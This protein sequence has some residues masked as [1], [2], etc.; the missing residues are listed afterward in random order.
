[1]K[2][3]NFLSN[4]WSLLVGSQRN[5]VEF[6]RRLTVGSPSGF[7][8]N[9]T[10]K[11]VSV[12]VLVLT[13][14]IGNAWGADGDVAYTLQMSDYYSGTKPSS[15]AAT[16]DLVFG[17]ASN[18]KTWNVPGNV[19][20]GN[21]FAIG[22][23][24]L[25]NTDRVIT[26]KST[27]TNIIK[28][29]RVNYSG[30]TN[31]KSSSLT[32]NSAKLE[33]SSNSSFTQIV[34]TVNKTSL[35]ITS[36]SSSISFTPS[37]D[38]W[39]SGKYYRITFT[40]TT[41]G[42]KNSHF[43]VTSIVFIEGA[44]A[45]TQTLTVSK[46]SI[47]G[48]T[49]VQGSGPSSAQTFTVSGSNLTANVT[50]SA[51]TNFEVSKDGSS[52]A[53]SQTI[54]ASSTLSATTIYVRLKSGLAVNSYS[55][56]ITVASTGATSKTVSLS[57]SV[58]A[59][60]YTVQFSTG[61]GNPTVS[62]RTEASGGAGITLPSG[63]TPACSSDGWSFAGWGY[64]SCDDESTEPTLYIAGNKYYPS[65]NETLYAVYVKGK[66]ASTNY[67]L[68]SDAA[69]IVSG[70]NYVIAAYDNS[71]DYA[72]TA[73]IQSSY[74]IK[75]T[76]VTVTAEN[77]ISSPGA[78]IIWQLTNEGGSN[79]SLYNSNQS[80]Y[81]YVYAS[82]SFRN[83]GLNDSKKQ[84]TMTEEREAGYASTFA[85]NSTDYTSYYINY[86]AS[87]TDFG[88]KTSSDENL[89]LYKRQYT[90]TYE[91]NPTCC[92]KEV[93]LAHNSPSNGTVSFA[94]AGPI[95]TCSETTADRQ[96]TMTIT[97]AAGY[98]LT[99]FNYS[100]GAGTVSPTN[101]S[102]GAPNVTT[103]SATPQ[104]ITLTFAQDANGT[105]TANATFS[106]IA[107]TAWS[108]TYN[109]AAI[110]NPINLYI[111]QTA[112][113]V[114]TYTPSG[115]LNSEKDYDITKSS[116]LTQVS[117]TYAVEHP[118][119]TFRA[120]VVIDD[121]TIVLTNHNHTSLTTTV[122]VHV[123][124]LPLVHFV[125]IVHGYEFADVVGTIEDNVLDA[126][127]TTPTHDSYSG[128]GANDCE[129][130]H[131]RL[132]GWI[133]KTWADAHPDATHS[134]IIGAGTGVFIEAN[135]AINVLTYNGKTYYAVW[136]KLE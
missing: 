96:T 16:Q 11:L 73:E 78:I 132:V 90:G 58:T 67:K 52:Y 106:A 97:P 136:G 63:P 102:P 87:H 112:A 118:T 89:Y 48:L 57:G 77:V 4:L 107:P 1:M 103:N 9:W 114:A 46:S 21:Y 3:K 23:T 15:Y 62:S 105:C 25:S 29:V 91:S 100:T 39:A 116:G 82:G 99:A 26:G 70:E 83:L 41:T 121:G 20:L 81:L 50:V 109:S 124:P 17:T 119:Y 86:D 38:N 120:D 65:S 27:I 80:K 101:Q 94:P 59:P 131:T 98:T 12:L 6:D 37:A 122:H 18:N 111:G 135:T 5:D 55:G 53:A 33:V 10:L 66:T 7:T 30:V 34:E 76:A 22:G 85:F 32:L 84:F 2:S 108:W 43:D 126:D 128:T 42:S 51:P 45:A 127:K 35:N 92:D 47:S 117:K 13:I 123:A 133:E 113:L 125:D 24:S 110:P 60:A 134:D 14:G 71:N 69:Q 28:E 54:T 36:G 64:E 19:T 115:L 129:T 68:I 104:V 79:V 49:Y 31:G 40:C 74:Y 130:D 56:N 93:T 95:E 88:T 75:Q 72:I 8:I 61:T 44:A